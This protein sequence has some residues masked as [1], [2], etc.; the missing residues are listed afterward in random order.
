VGKILKQ[1]EVMLANLGYL[2]HMW[3][4]Y[5]VWAWLPLFILAS[6]IRSG[7]AVFWAGLGSFAVIA[8]GGLGSLWAGQ[9]ADHYGRAPVAA[10]ALLISGSCAAGIGFLFGGNPVLVIAG[11]LIWGFTVVADSAQFS[12]TIS[13]LAPSEYMGTALTLQTSL[14]FLLT[15]FT[16]RLIPTLETAVGWRFAFLSLAPGPVLGIAAM[17]ALHR[18][19]ANGKAVG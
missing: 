11:A 5:A 8:V 7:T 16:I 13:E 17:I 14:G 4:L 18:R 3:E 19:L 10:G 6:F 15:L 9:L 12:A 1:R 2:G